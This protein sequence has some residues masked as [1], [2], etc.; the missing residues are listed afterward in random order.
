MRARN[1]QRIKQASHIVGHLF[2]GVVAR[3]RARLSV[4]TRVKAQHLVVL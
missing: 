2:E 4:A 1:V 3:W